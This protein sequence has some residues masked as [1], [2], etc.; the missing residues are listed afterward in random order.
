M[1]EEFRVESDDDKESFPN[2]IFESPSRKRKNIIL[3][4]TEENKMHIIA[5]EKNFISIDMNTDKYN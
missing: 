1:P 4:S 2:H 3:E 5:T